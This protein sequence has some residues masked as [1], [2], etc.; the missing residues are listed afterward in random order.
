M[1]GLFLGNKIL[2]YTI[3]VTIQCPGVT[4]VSHIGTHRWKKYT[5]SG[6][7]KQARSSACLVFVIKYVFYMI[8]HS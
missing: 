5:E 1:A 8:L 7:S 6:K 2:A 4:R 3:M